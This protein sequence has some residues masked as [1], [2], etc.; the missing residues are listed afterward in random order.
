[1]R[2]PESIGGRADALSPE[3]WR[4]IEEIL[5]E[6]L[7]LEAPERSAFLEEVCRGDDRLRSEVEAFLAADELGHPLLD[8][9]LTRLPTSCLRELALEQP[10]VSSVPLGPKLGPGTRLGSYEILS[11]AG[12]GGMGEVY[13]AEDLMLGRQ[14]AI[15]V[16]RDETGADAEHLR[17]LEHLRELEQRLRQ[18]EQEARAASRLNH[19]NIV[20]I[21]GIGEERGTPYIVM[22]HVEGRTLRELQASGPLPARDLFRL[23]TQMATGLAKAHAAGIVHRDLKPENV[24]V[25]ADGFV[26]I[27]DFGLIKL[28]ADD[29]QGD[30][31]DGDGE[32]PRGGE[33]SRR[34]RLVGT[35]GYMSPEQ[36]RREP[37]DFRSDQFALGAILHEMATG[38]PAFRREGTA[39]TLAAI[40]ESGPRP[41]LGDEL[42]VRFRS[43][44][45][46]CL[47]KDPAERFDSTEDLARELASFDGSSVRSGE[48]GSLPPEAREDYL[49]GLYLLAQ[50]RTAALEKS[51]EHFERVIERAP[52]H[53]P[54]YSGLG[55]AL[56]LLAGAGHG[57]SARSLAE[58][59]EHAATRA[60]ELDETLAAAHTS[61]GFLRFKFDWDWE[62]AEASFRRALELDPTDANAHHRYA[63]YLSALARHEEAKLHVGEARRIDPLSLIIRV[64]ASRVLQFA[65][66]LDRALELCHEALELDPGYAEAHFNLGMCRLYEG[67]YP[68]S[69]D[70]LETAV[71]LVGERPLFLAVL[72][73]VL[74]RAG[75]SDEVQNLLTRLRE[76]S[77]TQPVS[78][79]AFAIIY[80]G[81]GDLD[82]YFEAVDEAID[83]RDPIMV[84][85]PVDP[86]CHGAHEDPRF[87]EC[88]RRIGLPHG[89]RLG[90]SRSPGPPR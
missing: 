41:P 24:M 86:L 48:P 31:G 42:P 55:D 15:K 12:S 23:G 20:T 80:C 90:L 65:G 37:V 39:E 82:R 53:A 54:A 62:G 57:A 11:R 49:L 28:I 26:K 61:L 63:L 21:H 52:E 73:H 19:P 59:A 47:A 6:A 34:S 50:R 46:R 83:R 30:S 56:A 22:E 75:R 76:L 44:V 4:R 69:I 25:S 68:E 66:E 29:P 27:L 60:L 67:K 18:L 79:T 3:R 89:G 36:V 14:V 78:P 85:G 7:D 1:M 77:E 16:L 87:A 33:S 2:P 40:L 81:L 74:A 58:R 17:R 5:D 84:Y 72:G 43:L 45:E 32:H 51:V 71:A 64:A 13:R 8:R 38:R 9:T 88:I 35:V 70:A 10:R